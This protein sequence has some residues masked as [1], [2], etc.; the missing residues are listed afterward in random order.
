VIDLAADLAYA[1]A[2]FG[3]S[4]TLPDG[5]IVGA[6]ISVATADQTL[7]DVE[8]A[9]KSV[10]VRLRAG[11]APSLEENQHLM[12]QGASRR[13]VRIARVGGGAFLRCTMGGAS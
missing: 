1:M 5:R 11:D 2:D 6:I 9:G 10:T 3:Q 13:I 12:V 7:G 8:M 4:V